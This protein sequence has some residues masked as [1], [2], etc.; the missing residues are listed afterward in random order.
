MYKQIR[1]VSYE[2]NKELTIMYKEVPSYVERDKSIEGSKRKALQKASNFSLDRA[3]EKRFAI[4]SSVGM[5][6]KLISLTERLS[7]A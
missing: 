4:F 3:F 1:S 6:T 5:Y 7:L 2:V